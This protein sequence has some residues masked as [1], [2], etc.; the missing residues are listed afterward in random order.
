MMHAKKAITHSLFAAL[1][2]FAAGAAQLPWESV[3]EPE[4][5]KPYEK[6]AVNALKE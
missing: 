3:V 4:S 5:P 2:A 1:A 6:T